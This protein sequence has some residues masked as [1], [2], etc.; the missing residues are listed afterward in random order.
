MTA[1]DGTINGIYLETSILLSDCNKGWFGFVAAHSPAIPRDRA[2]DSAL[3]M[4]VTLGSALA[5]GI[6]L[7]PLNTHANFQRSW[8]TRWC[9][10]RRQ[11]RGIGP[12]GVW[13]HA[14]TVLACRPAVAN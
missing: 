2:V 8:M 5:A 12:A 9:P 10:V 4:T 3:N 13:N 1:S 14:D 7:G 6:E 11:K